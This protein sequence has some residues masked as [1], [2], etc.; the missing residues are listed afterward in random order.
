[1]DLSGHDVRNEQEDDSSLPLPMEV[2]VEVMEEH[3][4]K[5]CNSTR[6][7]FFTSKIYSPATIVDDHHKRGRKDGG[8]RCAKRGSERCSDG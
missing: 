2:E 5:H 1:M 7:D 4:R 6:T 3:A 8:G